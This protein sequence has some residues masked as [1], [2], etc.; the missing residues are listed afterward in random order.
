M[1]KRNQQLV[2]V[3]VLIPVL[4]A[5][6]SIVVAIR[7]QVRFVSARQV[8]DPIFLD[9]VIRENY[10]GSEQ[11]DPKVVRRDGFLIFDFRSQELCG[12]AGCL[13]S[14]YV[15]GDSISF[16][17]QKVPKDLD[18]FTFERHGAAKCFVTSQSQS[19]GIIATRYC[20]QQGK[21]A[22]VITELKKNSHPEWHL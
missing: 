11:L 22:K 14:A 13:Y 20:Y 1:P 10:T 15:D 21:L 5:V 19:E 4:V 12:V 17:L 6:F 2:V 9:S 16:Y 8:V 3:V 18:L 7:Q